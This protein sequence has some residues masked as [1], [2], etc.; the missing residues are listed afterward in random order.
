MTHT[1]RRI[2]APR[3]FTLYE[4]LVAAVIASILTGI[5]YTV[6]TKTARSYRVQSLAIGMQ[7]QARFAIDH[8]RRDISLAGFNA[9]P[10]STVD[11]NLCSQPATPLKAIRLK[12]SAVSGSVAHPAENPNIQPLEIT[13]FGDYTGSNGEVFYTESITGNS[14]RLQ[15]GFETRITDAQFKHIFD[16]TGQ[17]R[18]YLRIVDAEQ[19][20]MYIPITGANYATREITL[21]SPPPVR[22][23]TQTCGIQGFGQGLQVSPAMY[24]RY[25][26]ELVDADRG[27]SALIREDV[28]TD[29]VAA[30]VNSKLLIADNVVDLGA[31]D[32]VFDT[33]LTHKSPLLVTTALP[34]ATIVDDSGDVGQLGS[35]S[36]TVQNL[37]FMTV[38]VTVR[39]DQEDDERQH[40]P[41]AGTF[42]R[43]DSFDV[44]PGLTGAARAMTLTSKVM[45]QTLAVR[46]I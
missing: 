6:Y 28:T 33:D 30:V 14:V 46:N 32:F 13:L 38:K 9:T 21:T 43:I 5:I 4:L 23:A 26:V 36:S 24:V 8:L 19:Y 7:Q 40:R 37:R 35:L 20:E 10:N 3:G 12:K 34:D 29:G 39:S 44:Y 31:Y 15:A 16:G 22:S 18:R 2:R 45:L 41:R 17:N 27:R 42:T 1:A 11:P 25:R